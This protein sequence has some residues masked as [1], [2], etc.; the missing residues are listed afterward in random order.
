MKRSRSKI[1]GG[2]LGGLAESMGISP[3]WLRA[4]VG[5]SL[6][7]AFFTFNWWWLLVSPT[8]YVVLW[9]IMDRPAPPTNA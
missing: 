3:F 1:V 2:V 6:V 7:L 9:L 8:V 5:V 4:P